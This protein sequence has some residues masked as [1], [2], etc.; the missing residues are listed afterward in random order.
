MCTGEAATV[1]WLWGDSMGPT[2][3]GTCE[4]I[5]GTSV[6]TQ[7]QAHIHRKM[8]PLIGRQQAFFVGFFY[9][10]EKP[11]INSFWRSY[12]VIHILECPCG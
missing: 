8:T 6:D 2:W 3:L 11:G 4:S 7:G 1:P 9:L 12:A 10:K 5:C